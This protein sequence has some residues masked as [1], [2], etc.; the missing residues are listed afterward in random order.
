MVKIVMIIAPEN[1][2]DEEFQ[3]P[4]GVFEEKGFEVTVAS[5]GVKEAKGMLGGT[6]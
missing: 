1:Y 2:R 3:E 6:A 5:K 4:K